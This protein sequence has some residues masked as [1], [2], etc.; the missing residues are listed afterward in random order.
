V[1]PT[2]YADSPVEGR[3]NGRERWRSQYLWDHSATDVVG[4]ERAL[5]DARVIGLMAVIAF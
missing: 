5:E 3:P 1:N 2:A 4:A